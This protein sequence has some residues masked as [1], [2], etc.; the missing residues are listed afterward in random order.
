MNRQHILVGNTWIP[1]Q[2]WQEAIRA[3]KN[4]TAAR[5]QLKLLEDGHWEAL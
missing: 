5:E 1:R 2:E 3:N 4:G